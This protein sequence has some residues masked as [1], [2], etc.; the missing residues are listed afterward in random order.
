MGNGDRGSPWP[1]WGPDP[2]ELLKLIEFSKE[3]LKT[4]PDYLNFLRF[5]K[6]SRPSD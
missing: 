6:V 4:P 5:S 3:L 1:G 2:V